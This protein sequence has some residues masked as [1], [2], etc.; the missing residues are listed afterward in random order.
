MGNFQP[1]EVV[2]HGNETQLQEGELKK[3]LFSALRCLVFVS[4]V[5]KQAPE[6]GLMLE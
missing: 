1:L 5:T 6:V 3:T 4:Y 2:D